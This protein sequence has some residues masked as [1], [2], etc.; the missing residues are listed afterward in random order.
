MVEKLD[1]ERAKRD[2]VLHEALD[3]STEGEDEAAT[4]LRIFN[5][6][7][8]ANSRPLLKSEDEAWEIL[9]AF[10]D[11]LSA[12]LNFIR[13]QSTFDPL[14]HPRVYRKSTSTLSA[15]QERRAAK[16]TANAA[17]FYMRQHRATK[18][19]LVE[20]SEKFEKA[21][22]HYAAEERAF[23]KS[24]AHLAP[25]TK[26][27]RNYTGYSARGASGAGRNGEDEGAV[28]M[29]VASYKKVTGAVMEIWEVI[30]FERKLEGELG[31][32]HDEATSLF[33]RCMIDA[34]GATSLNM[35]DGGTYAEFAPDDELVSARKVVSDFCSTK[36]T[37]ADAPA[38][39]A[40]RFTFAPPRTHLFDPK[41]DPAPAT[42]QPSPSAS[43]PPAPS[44]PSH[45]SSPPTEPDASRDP[46]PHR[47]S[48]LEQIQAWAKRHIVDMNSCIF[49]EETRAGKQPRPIAPS[50][51]QDVIDQ[52][53]SILLNTFGEVEIFRIL[54]DVTAE[55]HRGEASFFGGTAGPGP[56]EF[57]SMMGWAWEALGETSEDKAPTSLREL[58]ASF[59]GGFLDLWSVSLW[60]WWLILV[61]M[62]LSRAWL[63]YRPRIGVL[64]SKH[65]SPAFIQVR[66]EAHFL[67]LAGFRSRQREAP[68]ESLESR[69]RSCE[70]QD[71]RR[72][73]R[74]VRLRGP[75]RTDS[76]GSQVQEE[77]GTDLRVGRPRR[78]DDRHAY[79]SRR[80]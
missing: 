33:E 43:P 60:H 46:P 54:K 75:R 37:L 11:S 19:V 69:R 39:I 40:A 78:E 28:G 68:R 30:G 66:C 50:A 7:R 5:A 51:L 44:P 70:G 29:R 23:R 1:A 55:A 56:R 72:R 35:A 21:Y 8:S 10:P 26:S 74:L 22:P 15:S 53:S 80:P 12:L 14:V 3:A 49:D 42:D 24:I 64:H 32:R 77:R 16:D 4:L 41:F 47:A 9:L 34:Q 73:N 18:K 38:A 52:A 79:R 2:D 71:L 57:R 25:T 6:I 31:E 48:L 63:V 17:T 27:G 58:V 62:F 36:L 67:L 65:V 13:H 61:L 20:A 59:G 45:P 76:S